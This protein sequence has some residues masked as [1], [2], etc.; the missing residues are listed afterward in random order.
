MLF[1]IGNGTRPA[2]GSS[3]SRMGHV[4]AYASRAQRRTT[5]L[6][7]GNAWQQYMRLSSFVTIFWTVT[8]SFTQSILHCCSSCLNKKWKAFFANGYW[9]YKN[10]ILRSYTVKAPQMGMP[11]PYHKGI[12]IKKIPSTN[13]CCSY[14]CLWA[15]KHTGKSTCHWSCMPIGHQSVH[16]QPCI[17]RSHSLHADVW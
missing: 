12:I 5:V 15:K 1:Q 4:I 17:Y 10:T 13:R 6:S 3:N 16:L 2:E 8:S 7:K 9:H 11:M 14:F